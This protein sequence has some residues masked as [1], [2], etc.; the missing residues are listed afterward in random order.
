MAIPNQLFIT[1]KFGF[2]DIKEVKPKG[3]WIKLVESHRKST[4]LLH[5][6]CYRFI[7]R[8][9]VFVII[10]RALLFK[11]LIQNGAHNP[12]TKKMTCFGL[13]TI[14]LVFDLL[15]KICEAS[16]QMML[17]DIP[18]IAIFD[19]LWWLSKSESNK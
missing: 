11:K 19:W 12:L 6:A 13:L 3:Q 18:K 16:T 15:Y 10:Y 17:P 14:P 8:F 7:Q 1:F 5:T 4:F 9:S 2:F